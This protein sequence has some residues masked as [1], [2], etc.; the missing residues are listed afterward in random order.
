[1]RT[2]FVTTA[3]LLMTTA[4]DATASNPPEAPQLT[5]E[6]G[7]SF[8]F[9]LGSDDQT[10]GLFITLSAFDIGQS[11][12]IPESS[13][14]TSDV[15]RAELQF[16]ADLFANWCDDV[17]EPGEPEPEI[18]E[19]WDLSGTIEILELPE[20]GTCGPARALLAG[21][22]AHSPDGDEVLALGDFDV[23]NEFWGC[24]AG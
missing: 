11:G 12:D 24:F 5:E 18:A 15:W 9:Y 16:G 19:T 4:C 7:C 17:L 2:A 1:M 13:S 6:Y 3:L 20:P 8:G 23:E 10:A 14:L 21:V 22:D